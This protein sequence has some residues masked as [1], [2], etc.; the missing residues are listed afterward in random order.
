LL[1]YSTRLLIS[2]LQLISKLL[3]S[4]I[5]N[6]GLILVLQGLRRLTK[7]CL[8]WLLLFLIS[9]RPN[10]RSPHCK[11]LLLRL[12]RKHT[13][14]GRSPRL[15]S[16]EGTRRQASRS[17][18]AIRTLNETLPLAWRTKG[19]NRRTNRPLSIGAGRGSTRS[20]AARRRERARHQT[21]RLSHHLG[22]GMA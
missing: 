19:W 22:E 9:Q 14:A 15:P 16:D 3:L 4:L 21:R 12:R 18:G 13:I 17:P 10:P 6:G 11:Q 2:H 5:E 1:L 7:E 20:Q 8:G